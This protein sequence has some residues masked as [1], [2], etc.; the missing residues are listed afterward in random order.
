MTVALDLGWAELDRVVTVLADQIGADGVPDVVVGLLRGGAVP[1][2]MIAHRLGVRSVRTAE[3]RRTLSDAPHAPK[4]DPVLRH[5]DVLGDLSGLDVLLVD[6]V[7]GTGLTVEAA[8]AAV[9]AR[10]PARLRRAV[11]V[12]NTEA[13]AAS[14]FAAGPFTWFDHVGT[15]SAGW[16]RFPWETA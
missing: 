5:G 7:A 10:R 8:T 11:T 4:V 16:V 12:V 14:G 15:A 13:W 3:V 1:A 2:V 9:I 6:D